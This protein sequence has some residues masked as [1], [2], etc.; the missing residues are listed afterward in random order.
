MELHEKLPRLVRRLGGDLY[1]V[2]DLKPA[3]EAIQKQGGI[4]VD[5]YPRAVTIGIRL[6]D[7][8]IDQLP[9][10][11]DT[12]VLAVTYQTECYEYINKRLN[13]IA[14]R[15][16][17]TLQNEGFRALPI[18][19]AER[20]DDERICAMF[21]HKMAAHL[22]GL[23]WIGRSCLLITPQYGPR[24]RWV[25]ILT[26]APLPSTGKP[27]DQQCMFCRGCVDACPVSAFTGKSF[28]ESEPR[29]ARY[30]ARKCQDYLRELESK[31]ELAVCGMCIAVCPHGRKRKKLSDI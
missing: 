10:K 14:S 20:I 30:D 2:A 19:A 1:G 16:A 9:E 31:K 27:M 4:D 15:V 22:A 18:P 21:S 28:V 23:G 6:M 12:R 8:I 3:A 13:D 11:R 26:N 29:E 5:E 17:S 24:V 25:T 7:S